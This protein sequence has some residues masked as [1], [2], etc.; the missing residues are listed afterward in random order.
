MTVKQAARAK[1]QYVNYLLMISKLSKHLFQVTTAITAIKLSG[2]NCSI[3]EV[4][5]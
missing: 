1:G 2:C 4:S 3:Y 5:E